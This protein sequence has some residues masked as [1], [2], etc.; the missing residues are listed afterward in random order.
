[1]AIEKP[2]RC[3]YR[4]VGGLY[5]VGEMA[6]MMSCGQFPFA[7][8]QCPCCGSGFAQGLGFK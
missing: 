3:G 5:M 2:R 4:K 1:M 6:S 8:T 7:L